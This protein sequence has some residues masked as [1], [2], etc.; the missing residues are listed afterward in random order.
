[1]FRGPHL[2]CV[3]VTFLMG[4]TL[5]TAFNGNAYWKQ[6]SPHTGD[7]TVGITLLYLFLC[8]LSPYNILYSYLLL[9]TGT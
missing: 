3:F 8:H 1:M 9:L 5:T 4:S 7:V 2:L 6:P